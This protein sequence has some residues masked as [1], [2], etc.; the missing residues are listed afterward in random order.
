MAIAIT[1]LILPLVDAAKQI[2]EHPLGDVLFDNLGLLFAFLVSFLV[3]GREWIVHHRVFESVSDYSNALVLYNLLWLLSIVFLPFAA[4]VLAYIEDEQPAVFA[5]YIGTIMVTSASM[6]LM[7]FELRRHPTL[8]I[9]H[10]PATI[11]VVGGVIILG[12]MGVALIIAVVVP[13]INMWALLLLFLAGP[14]EAVYSRLRGKRV[15]DQPPA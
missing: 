7:E 5:L 13:S 15:A 8:I 12:L 2:A 6:L 11:P 4:N 14:V 3:I 1:I 10:D 9:D